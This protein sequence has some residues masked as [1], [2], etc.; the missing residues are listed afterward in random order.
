MRREMKE[1]ERKVAAKAFA[2]KW[3]GVGDEKQHTQTFWL[4][5]LQQVFGVEQPFGFITFEDTVKLGHVSFIDATIPKTHVM[6]EQKG[7]GKDLAKPIRQS[8]G[9]FLTPYQQAKR[10]AAELP[11][12][13]RPRWIVASNFA[14]FRV[15]DMENP[16]AE[17]EIILL[18]NLPK[19]FY[20]LQF[21]VNEV[22]RDIKREME[23]SLQAGEIVGKL[24][25]ALKKKYIAPESENAL[26][27]L[28]KLCV[29][30]VFC[31]Y[32]ESAGIFGKRNMFLE[33][34][35]TFQPQNVRRA[36]I[37]LF[38]ALNT[39]QDERDPYM[40]ENLAAFPY[41][42][43]GLFE[44]EKI[45]IP[46]LDEEILDLLINRAGRDFDWS[47]ISPTIFGAVFESTLNPA[48][49]RKGGMHY[50]SIENIHKVIDPLFLD[51]LKAEFAAIKE[52]KNIKNRH[53][54]LKEFQNKLA[55]IVCL[56]PAC[57]SG[58]FLTESYI[59]LR[60]LENEV[61]RELTGEQIIMGGIDNPIKVSIGQ[62]YGIE[63]NDFAVTVAK[64]ALWIAESQTL[65]ET[66][67]IIH[68][69]L[70]FLPLKSYTNIVEG[71]A[72]RLDWDSVAPRERVNYIMGN[73]PFVGAAN[74]TAEQKEDAV[75]IFGKIKLSN[76]IDYV[77][78]W[79][80]KAAEYIQNTNINCAFVS[81]NSITQGEQVAPLW[82]NLFLRYSI[83]L[84]FAYRTFQWNSESN[85][86]AKVHCV[87]IG[88]GNND[89]K[90]QKT[91]F[92]NENK[93][94]AS[95]ISPYV[96]DAPS[97]FVESRSNPLCDVPKM[98][99]GNQATDDGNFIFSEDEYKEFIKKYPQHKN[100]LHRYLGAK[101]FLHGVPLR[102]C[103]WLHEVPVQDYANNKEIMRRIE[104]VREF[105]QK[106]SAAPT[107]KSSEQPYKFFSVP[108]GKNA[109]LVIPRVSSEKRKYVPVDFVTP[110][111]IVSD[112]LSIV[113]NATLYHFGVLMSNVHNAWLRTVAGR[114]E[115]RYRYSGSIVYNNFPWVNADDEQKRKIEITAQAILNARKE[116]EGT[117][118]AMLYNDALM[119]PELRRAHQANDRAVMRAYGFDLK[120][121]EA[122]CVAELFK[123][124]QE[125]TEG[126]V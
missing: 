59:S 4:E 21:L 104:A 102:Y 10:Y 44:E 54:L 11:Y 73:P 80:Y 61:L 124:Y 91:I 103:L 23:I 64:T 55:G 71:N 18:K 37:D 123:M 125:L 116:S 88:F 112:A 9:T 3:N 67:N 40:N 53:D 8:D 5:L 32:A 111:I 24:Y 52:R 48:T 1:S 16:Q 76:S 108:Q 120:M 81:T 42:N 14:E 19:E 62:F 121:T 28:N 87:I 58:N 79:Y 60:R 126:R 56:D 15:Y 6:I 83:E 25:A 84:N 77:G 106:S 51:A 66:K 96:L 43:G 50:T 12:S 110:D 45:E 117:P 41:V 2:D 69:D 89:P 39:P 100:L 20:R 35:L 68:M 27:S 114:L 57:G 98:T 49:R 105:R 97:V 75:N 70:D 22:S 113:P 109:C 101:D 47:G 95:N 107:R 34:L 72:L 74:M 118:L 99:K 78:A 85:D 115:M 7:L 33:Y 122:A 86:K 36:L 13:K 92:A 26:K 17:P 38:E 93:F 94:L 29:R 90:T 46:Q 119:P 30:L 31:L 65:E 82:K 63:I